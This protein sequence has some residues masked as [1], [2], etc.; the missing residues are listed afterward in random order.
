L[1]L[2]EEITPDVVSLLFRQNQT[3][4]L[5]LKKKPAYDN[6]DMD[7]IYMN[8]INYNDITTTTTTTT[9]I[10]DN[11]GN[12]D[13]IVIH[14]A[15]SIRAY[16]AITNSSRQLIWLDLSDYNEIVDDQFI[17]LIKDAPL[18]SNVNLSHCRNLTYASIAQTFECE[19]H[20]YQR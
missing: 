5:A 12:N 2:C 8:I 15:P 14:R 20:D 6:S 7:D 11:N 10:I 13:D 3:A 16:R 9:N 17:A 18:L 1:I 4:R 19:L